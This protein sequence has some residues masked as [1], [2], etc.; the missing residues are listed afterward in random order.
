[1][2]RTCVWAGC[3]AIDQPD[4][5]QT[6]HTVAIADAPF[7]L[8]VDE[9]NDTVYVA[10]TGLEE[11]QT[12]YANLTSGISVINGAGCNATTFAGC[13][14]TPASVPVGGFPWDVTV[15][16]ASQTVYVTSTVDSDVA[17]FDAATC[18]G[19]SEG[20]LPHHHPAELTG[21]WPA[22]IGIDPGANTLYVTN[23]TSGGVSIFSLRTP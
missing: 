11:F 23:N 19:S 3:D 6:A 13:A 22:Y 1:M 15:N 18:N 14:Y 7:G 5:S 20:K 9:Q 8:A 10:N 21:G 4:C 12:G 2:S 16:P 17:K